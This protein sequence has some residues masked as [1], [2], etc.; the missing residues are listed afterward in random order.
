MLI[1]LLLLACS[2]EPNVDATP[3]P[4]EQPVEAPKQKVTKA[5]WV[6]DWVMGD[7][8]LTADKKQQLKFMQDGSV[9]SQGTLEGKGL[10][11]TAAMDGCGAKL[12]LS[13]VGGDIT[14]TLSG[15]ECP[16]EF[17]GTYIN[18]VSP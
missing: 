15:P 6:G 14:V 18:T 13:E 17:A 10:K 7:K 4:E 11:R 3:T 12:K 9:V 1:T 16:I 5:A 2:S 8:I